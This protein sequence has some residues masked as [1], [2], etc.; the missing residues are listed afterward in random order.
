MACPSVEELHLVGPQRLK[1]EKKTKL[2]GGGGVRA[3]A[4]GPLK[5]GLFSAFPSRFEYLTSYIYYLIFKWL[6]IQY[7][8]NCVT[9]ILPVGSDRT[10]TG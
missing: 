5:K 2:E 9:I 10:R 8:S 4:V 7:I 1:F 6:N 3:L